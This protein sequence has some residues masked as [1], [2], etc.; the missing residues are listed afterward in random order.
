MNEFPLA[1]FLFTLAADGIRVTLKDYDRIGLALRA[2][3]PW[4][5]GR[6]RGV[7]VA[8]LVKSAEQEQA[9]V[10]RFDEFFDPGLEVEEL[11]A[12][13]LEQLWA[14]LRG[15]VGE[16]QLSSHT[17]PPVALRAP[18]GQSAPAQAQEPPARLRL[19][20]YRFR[21][22]H[23][24]VPLALLALGALLWLKYARPPASSG[25][26]PNAPGPVA[27]PPPPAPDPAAVQTTTTTGVSVAVKEIV[28]PVRLPDEHDWRDRAGVGALCLLLALAYAI[29]LWLLS[30]LP[31]RHKFAWDPSGKRHFPLGQIG[32]RAAPHLDSGTLD[33]LADSLGYF[34]SEAAGTRLNVRASVEAMA[35]RS[36][37]PLLVFHKRRQLRTVYILEDAYAQP[38]SW[39]PVPRELAEG[40]GRRGIQI[41]YGRFYGSPARFQIEG[42]LAWLE[43]LEAQRQ[44]HLLL[45]F[46]DGK[47]LH[48]HR[49]AFFLETLARWPFLAWMELREPRHWDESTALVRRYGLP[50][51]QATGAGLL[52]AMRSFLT[53]RSEGEDSS[54]GAFEWKGV[55]AS[56]GSDLSIYVEG[57]LGD[58]LPWGQACAMIQPVTAGMADALR[59]E[60]QPHLPPDRIE[61]L[62]ALPG[63]VV[64]ASGIRFSVPVLAVL[65]A[66]FMV[67]WEQPRQEEILRFLLE[68][69][70]ETE[71]G[72]KDSL[73]HLAWRW[74]M[75]RVRLELEPDGA[76]EQ[77][78]RLGETPLKG[79]IQTEL[80]NVVLPGAALREPGS[81]EITRVPLRRKP[82]TREAF[83]YL[84]RVATNVVKD[85]D[86]KPSLAE[87]VQVY[88]QQLARLCE[89][90]WAGLGA[91]ISVTA[92]ALREGVAWLSGKEPAPPDAFD[93]EL[94]IVPRPRRL[95][96]KHV[97]RNRTYSRRLNIRTA[98]GNWLLGQASAD[99][100]W[101]RVE[102]GIFDSEKS[103]RFLEVTVDTS[104]LEPGRHEANVVL[105]TA[106][107]ET[108][109]PLTLAVVESS[110]ERAAAWWRQHKSAMRLRAPLALAVLAAAVVFVPRALPANWVNRLYNRPPVLK[111]L[112]EA[113]PLG[114]P[115]AGLKFRAEAE[116][117]DRDEVVRYEWAAEG[118]EIE[119]DK[120]S[121]VIKTAGL[122]PAEAGAVSEVTLKLK[123][124][125][126]RGGQSAYIAK[127]KLE[128][129]ASETEVSV[130]E[131]DSPAVASNNPPNPGP[132]GDPRP[133]RR[134]DPSPTRPARATRKL[135]FVADF[136]TTSI[137]I[138]DL[139][140]NP[141]VTLGLSHIHAF[142]KDVFVSEAVSLKDVPPGN[143]IIRFYSSI[144]VNEANVY[145]GS[146]DQN[147]YLT[148]DPPS[149]LYRFNSYVDDIQ[150]SI[151]G[152]SPV[153]IQRT[154]VASLTRG[155]HKLV[156][157]KP[158]YKQWEQI[159]D[160]D[161][162]PGRTINIEMQVTRE[163]RDEATEHLE[164]GRRYSSIGLFPQALSEFEE[165]LKIDRTRADAWVEMALIAERF[166][167]SEEVVAFCMEA[168]QLQPNLTYAYVVRGNAYLKVSNYLLAISDANTA[169]GLRPDRV[170]A[171]VLRGTAYLRMQ[172]F[173][174]ATEDAYKALALDPDNAEAKA[175]MARIQKEK[176]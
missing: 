56:V 90:L 60:F 175:L 22:R 67:R 116:D 37:L 5:V 162:S 140:N 33:Q 110:A 49:D 23:L 169:I 132:A 98:S 30:R 27:P 173:E 13:E 91:V 125:D 79:A 24:L 88:L 119:S 18:A 52:R 20:K 160:T 45:F 130:S 50:V 141:V 127:V 157:T 148:F 35:R 120:D 101:V 25:P 63:T 19:P 158:G 38:L 144:T 159:I 53:E 68:K 1:P 176:Q 93:A 17:P 170:D 62:F 135:T 75:E 44:H 70:A 40:L 46:S 117:P 74:S 124:R 172:R 108:L 155:Q 55:P 61:R 156:V 171:Y 109:V 41:K 57:L 153:A 39:N 76:L 14:Q 115:G 81:T 85:P 152:K 137:E 167:R 136:T 80:A 36:G 92:G 6:L 121:A 154:G 21:P 163:S 15:L 11:S 128:S 107:R 66:G 123:L 145:I 77:I 72:Q 129:R 82:R 4:S 146:S 126:A 165:A 65:R 104:D 51:F 58:A 73:A 54:D 9:F 32:G 103:E 161:K 71:P 174:N 10:R 43:D 100:K 164:K 2:G 134:N 150:L 106:G 143:Y 31:T 12:A 28:P 131:G 87:R 86:Y 113:E 69:I 97:R 95:N 168:I 83:S 142:G 118:G 59:R 105:L 151:D 111:G 26:P 99:V 96:F 102:P 16:K 34:Q 147:I 94:E 138:R 8:L 139:N 122:A 166:N 48:Y 7:L 114:G 84:A 47:G 149:I 89:R 78:A 42:A 133:P 3:G 29:L 112:K 64:S